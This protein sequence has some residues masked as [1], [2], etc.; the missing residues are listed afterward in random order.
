MSAVPQT[1]PTKTSTLESID[2]A[3]VKYES[4]RAAILEKAFKEGGAA[5]VTQLE[6]EYQAL[7]DA[8][9]EL[10]NRNLAANSAKF[11]DLLKQ[12]IDATKQIN[13]S[14]DSL[15]SV[16]SVLNSI[17]KTVNLVGRIILL[18]GA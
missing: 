17:T 15:N 5:K 16:T 13:S 4:S 3:L 8:Y 9:F 6:D 10:L 14:I 2:A 12:T 18:F 7:Q 11:P 1:S